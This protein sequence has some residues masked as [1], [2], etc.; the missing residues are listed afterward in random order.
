MNDQIRTLLRRSALI[1]IVAS[2]AAMTACGGGGK[3]SATPTG[4]HVP[5]SI[6]EQAS[7][8]AVAETSDPTAAVPTT[9]EPVVVSTQ[10]AVLQWEAPQTRSDGSALV[11]L[12]G[13]RI[14]YGPDVSQMTQTVDVM[15]ASI[16]NYVVDG[17]APG[18]YYFAVTA[19]CSHGSESE[20]SNAGRKIII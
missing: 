18:T 3:T 10:N 7:T 17:L 1:A 5:S 15:N 14:Y 2:S 19:I 6:I 8:V 20:R 16:S 13:F 11:D 4:T 9:G 12:K